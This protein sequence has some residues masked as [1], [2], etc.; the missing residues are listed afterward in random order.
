MD[1]CANRTNG[2]EADAVPVRLSGLDRISRRFQSMVTT[3]LNLPEEQASPDAVLADPACDAVGS[4]VDFNRWRFDGVARADAVRGKENLTI[5][6][7]I[8]DD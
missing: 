8:P 5:S 2:P 6:S 4:A 3:I 7:R 1:R